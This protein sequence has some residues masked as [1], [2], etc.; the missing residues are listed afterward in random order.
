MSLLSIVQDC[1]EELGIQSPSSVVGNTDRQ[2][3]QIL[4]IANREGRDLLARYPWTAAIREATFTQAAASLQG[5]MTSLA[6]GFDYIMNDTMWNRT[7]SLPIM[8]PVASRDWQTLQAF[9]VTG[10]YQQFR[11]RDGKLY[12][13]PVGANATDTIAFEYKSKYFCESSGGTDQTE[14]SADADI[15]L[16]DEELMK[17]GIVWRWLKRKGLDYAEDFA[18]YERRVLDAMARDGGKRTLYTDS[19][20]TD[21][22][23]GIVVPIGSW[24]P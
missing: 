6:A 16:L 2:V 19:T 15:G 5:T 17:L 14:W 21:R 4:Q 12:F 3:I 7:T 22:A 8:G 1:C 18:T 20:K 23:P 9:P 24:S 13:D 11:I 10:P